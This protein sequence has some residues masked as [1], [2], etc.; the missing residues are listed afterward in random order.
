MPSKTLAAPRSTRHSLFLTCALACLLGACASSQR[1]VINTFR[2]AVADPSAATHALDPALS[3]LRVGANGRAV[4]MVLGNIESDPA[5]PIEVW[6]SAGREVLRLQNGRVVGAVGLTEEWRAVRM[7]AL[8][9]WRELLAA[10][11]PLTWTRGRDAMPGYRFGI[12]ET[13][14]LRASDPPARSA[15]RTRDAATLKW[16][17][18]QSLNATLPAARY[19]IDPNAPDTVIYGEQCLSRGL[20]LAWERWSVARR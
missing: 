10:S 14:T 17:E 3:Y 16:F 6:Y 11:E 8:P 5:G 12:H 19:A 18:E 20:C 7:P 4:L 9:S 1:A 13:L 15:L 2:E